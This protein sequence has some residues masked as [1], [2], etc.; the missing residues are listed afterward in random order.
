MG[1]S[2]FKPSP[3]PLCSALMNVV[4]SM[5]FGS[6]IILSSNNR[7]MLKLKNIVGV[8]VL[9]GVWVFHSSRYVTVVLGPDKKESPV[10]TCVLYFSRR[11]LFQSCVH[12]CRSYTIN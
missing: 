1:C 5:Q 8:S 3:A 10:F 6:G 2:G 9:S 4:I 11:Y 12:A 7:S